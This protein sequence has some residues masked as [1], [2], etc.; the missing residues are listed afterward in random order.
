MARVSLA[1]IRF[2]LHPSFVIIC[3]KP[4]AN[5]SS[6][7]MGLSLIEATRTP[8]VRIVSNNPLKFN[9][10]LSSQ[11]KLPIMERIQKKLSHAEVWDDSALQKSWDDAL[12]EYKVRCLIPVSRGTLL[13]LE[14]LYHGIHARGER[15]EDV[16]RE[17]EAEAETAAE[18]ERLIPD[19][20]NASSKKK[21]TYTPA[22][23]LEDNELEDGEMRDEYT[24]PVPTLNV[25]ISSQSHY[26][27]CFVRFS[28]GLNVSTYPDI[29]KHYA[30]APNAITRE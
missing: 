18:N 29:F 20:S 14:K 3:A 28:R 22:E 5:I 17:Y 4:N 19:E 2:S 25:C 10:R 15:V 7:E 8:P 16:L 9:T 21:P 13:I 12:S 23:H 24:E 27:S 26:L 11:V 1:S 6:I 30:S